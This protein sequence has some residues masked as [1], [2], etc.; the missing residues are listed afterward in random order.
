MILGGNVTVY[1]I[2]N[3]MCGEIQMSANIATFA[4]K[5]GG[6]KYG[7]CKDIGYTVFDHKENVSVGPFGNY[8]VN[9][10]RKN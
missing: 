3:G 9:I 1:K 5:F 10:F 2:D 8:E 7:N 4:V 6:V